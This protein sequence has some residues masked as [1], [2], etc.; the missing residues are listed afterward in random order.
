DRWF[1]GPRLAGVVRGKS[2]YFRG[3]CCRSLTVGAEDPP[4]HSPV[5]RRPSRAVAD[6]AAISIPISGCP[7]HGACHVN[8]PVLPFGGEWVGF[9]VAAWARLIWKPWAPA[10]R[11]QLLLGQRDN[12]VP[13][14]RSG[15]RLRP[16]LR[17]QTRGTRHRAAADPRPR[18][19]GE[20]GGG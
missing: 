19:E 18:A 2:R 14:P 10:A 3:S 8:W 20:R 7:S 6:R 12:A 1:A 5:N 16:R 15:P 9:W 4:R 11:F 13:A 17:G